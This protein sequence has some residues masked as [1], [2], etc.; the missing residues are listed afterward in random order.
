[1]ERRSAKTANFGIIYGISAFG[2]AERLGCSRSEA[3]ALIE[4]YFNTYPGVKAYMDKSIAMARE[5][6]YTQ[7]L[8]GRRCQLP[9]INSH[10]AIVRGYAERNAIN[11][12]IQGTAADIMKIAMIRIDKRLQEQK[13]R[14]RMI[15]QV[16]DELNF[17]VIPDEKVLIEQIVIEEMQNATNLRVPL[18]ADAGWGRNWLEAH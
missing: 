12:P 8:F 16:H 6:G 11:A 7:T 5:K 10:N 14:S 18:I 3:K 17:T 2:L 1:D 15:L 9:D 4:G 13:L